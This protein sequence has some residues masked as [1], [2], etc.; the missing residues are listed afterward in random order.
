M[1]QER[2]RIL[3]L[4]EN[5]QHIIEMDKKI[6]QLIEERD[7]AK[8]ME[9]ECAKNGS[10]TGAG[11]YQASY[12]NISRKIRKN[13]TELT[14]LTELTENERNIYYIGQTVY[15]NIKYMP[16]TSRIKWKWKLKKGKVISVEPLKVILDDNTKN[17]DCEEIIP[18]YKL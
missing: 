15:C 13:I 4:P 9:E 1:E 12:Y 5:E 10:P 14:E 6:T 8:F 7:Y 18:R 16:P 17:N 2:K 11:E 3:S